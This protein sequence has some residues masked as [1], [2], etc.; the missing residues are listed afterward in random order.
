MRKSKKVFVPLVDLDLQF[1]QLEKELTNV[2]HEVASGSA[3]IRGKKLEEFEQSFAEYHFAQHAIGVGSGTDALELA[4]KALMLRPGDEVI[5]V[6]N[7]WISTVFA[8][9]KGGGK[10]VFVD[11]DPDTYQIDPNK[12]EEAINKKT[13]AVIPVHLFGHPSPMTEIS[14]ICASKNI[15]II[16]DVAQATLAKY[17][18]NLTGTTGDI[19]CFSFYPSKPLGGFGDG[20]MVIT[21]NNGYADYIRQLSDYGQKNPYVHEHIGYNSR[22]DNIQAAILSKKLPHTDSWNAKRIKAALLYDKKLSHLGIKTPTTL[23]NALHI[24]HLYVIEVENRDKI[25]Y[26]L[27]DN[28]VM[29]QVHYPKVVHLQ[30]C[31][32]YLGYKKGDFPV[33]EAA[34]DRILS[35]PIYA[36]ILEE[37]IDIV[38]ETLAK[39]LGKV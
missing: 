35:L 9:C 34:A 7:T 17:D 20:G 28:G 6:P 12:L 31:F 16:E 4:V 38:I 3:F 26:Y 30:N 19:G 37:Q 5:T 27:R 39:A 36:E 14:D 13:K 22:L 32:N 33:A 1:Q 21:N 8:V 24:F 29:A 25:L 11:V 18:D 2:L 15:R 10:P 23:P